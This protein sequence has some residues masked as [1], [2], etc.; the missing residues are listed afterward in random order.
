MK[1][2][3]ERIVH[4]QIRH[5]LNEHPEFFT[6]VGKERISSISKRIAGDVNA[7]ISRSSESGKSATEVKDS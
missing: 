1:K 5:T 7:Y 6:D 3:I 4:G 2:Q